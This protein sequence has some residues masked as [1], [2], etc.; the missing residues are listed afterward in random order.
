MADQWSIANAEAMLNAAQASNDCQGTCCTA[1]VGEQAKA[2]SKEAYRQGVMQRCV[3]GPVGQ[4]LD[5]AIGARIRQ[6]GRSQGALVHGP[7]HESGPKQPSRHC[8]VALKL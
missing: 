4:A 6:Q 5:C 7:P 1:I 8:N 3:L 2:R